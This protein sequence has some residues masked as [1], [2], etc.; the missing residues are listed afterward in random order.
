MGRSTIKGK[1]DVDFLSHKFGGK[2]ISDWVKSGAHCVKAEKIRRNSG[3][4]FAVVSLLQ[5]DTVQNA[6]TVVDEIRPP[7]CQVR[8]NGSRS[9][10]H[11]NVAGPRM[12]VHQ[13]NNR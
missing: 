6:H 9:L 2:D 10:R 7:V 3:H 13:W 4:Y 5:L 8:Q 1:S 12:V 11:Q